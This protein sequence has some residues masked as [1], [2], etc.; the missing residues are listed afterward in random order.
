MM[1][2]QSVA[3]ARYYA[4]RGGELPSQEDQENWEVEQV[5][6]KGDVYTYHD[7]TKEM[8]DHMEFLRYLASPPASGAVAQSPRSG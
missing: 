3:A 1:E 4:G 8:K 6:T 5:K 7:V 2:Y